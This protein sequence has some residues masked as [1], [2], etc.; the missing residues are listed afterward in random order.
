M[1]VINL[2]N[3]KVSGSVF[4][5][6]NLTGDEND[7]TIKDMTRFNRGKNFANAFHLVYHGPS[8]DKEALGKSFKEFKN[9]NL[10]ELNE[11]EMWTD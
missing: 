4:P 10:R 2:A 9:T 7:Y 8:D 5:F 11:N 6:R 3:Y 1:Q